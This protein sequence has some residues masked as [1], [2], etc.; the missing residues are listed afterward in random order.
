MVGNFIG[1]GVRGRDLSRFDEEVQRGI[2]FHRFIDSTTDMHPEVMEAKK[3]FYPTQAKYAGVVLDVVFDHLL[4]KHWNEFHSEP[5]SEFADACYLLIAQHLDDIPTRSARF[6]Q[7]MSTNDIL[8][9]YRNLSGIEKVFKGMDSRTSFHSQMS[10]SIS[11][12]RRLEPELM[13]YFGRFF[14]DLV[15]RCTQWRMEH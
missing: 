9:G 5:L 12:I 3:L 14:P 1:D 4:A 13:Q 2:R 11:E 15:S 6:Y 7:Y 10:D 8:T